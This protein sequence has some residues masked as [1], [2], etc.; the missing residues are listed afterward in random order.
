MFV[1][2]PTEY[3]IVK[4]EQEMDLASAIAMTFIC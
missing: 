4:S 3:F 1:A 2:A